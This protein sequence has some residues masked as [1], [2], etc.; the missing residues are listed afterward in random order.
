MLSYTSYM[1]QRLFEM[2]RI[3]KDTGSIYLH[4]DPTAS[5]YLKLVMDA[6]F[7]EKNFRN[8]IVWCYKGPSSA[9]R[10][11]PRKHDIILFYGKTDAA[12]FNPDGARIDYTRV[13]GTGINSLTRGN[14]TPEEVQ[15]LEAAYA[16]RGK[17]IEDYWI[18]IPGGGHMSK[19]EHLGYPTQK[20]LALY[21]RIIKASSNA[22]DIVLDPFAGCGTTVEAAIKNNRR[23]IGIDILPFA[24][25]A[26]QS[27]SDTPEW[28]GGVPR[29]RRAS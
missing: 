26:H 25:T 19:H 8:E 22:K 27:A 15:K 14:R 9:K 2:H 5:H 4:C 16:K 17:L 12:F 1:A 13:S 21:E 10:W 20:P 28:K 24:A 18:D 11:Y 6:V 23:V 29:A 7:G 3:L